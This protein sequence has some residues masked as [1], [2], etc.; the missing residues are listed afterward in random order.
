MPQ[1]LKLSKT[2]RTK[3]LPNNRVF[4][5]LLHTTIPQGLTRIVECIG[6]V[7]ALVGDDQ[8]VVGRLVVSGPD[9]KTGFKLLP[10]S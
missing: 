2:W 3:K 10:D 6:F 7:V 9:K 4:Y 1:T 5:I 8:A